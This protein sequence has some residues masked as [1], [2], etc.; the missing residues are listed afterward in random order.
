VLGA[1]DPALDLISAWNLL[2][3]RPRRVLRTALSCTELE[4]ERSKAWAFQQAMGLVWYYA[5]SN[6][7]M[8]RLG[9]TTL[10]RIMS[11]AEALPSRSAAQDVPPLPMPLLKREGMT[12]ETT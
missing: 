10:R 5:D 3:A 4:W 8:S 7:V 2:E 1:A 11:A 12:P 9:R 6:P